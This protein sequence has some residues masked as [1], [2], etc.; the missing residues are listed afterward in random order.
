ML[1]QRGYKTELKLNNRQRTHCKQHAGTARFAYNWGLQRKIDEYQQSGKSLFGIDLHRE[2][3][4]LKKPSL[5][6]CTKSP[7]VL[8][9]KRCAI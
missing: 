4:T 6:G 3:N 8:L 2:L 5:R 1:V 7:N 9:K